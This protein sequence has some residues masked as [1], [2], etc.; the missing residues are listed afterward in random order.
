MAF[1]LN[2]NLTKK[3]SFRLRFFFFFF[4]LFQAIKLQLSRGIIFQID[5]RLENY[6]IEEDGK[7]P[8]RTSKSQ[9]NN[10]SARLN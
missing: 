2:F 5:F 7:R 10:L 6:E 9:L 1:F 3:P 4:I 8:I